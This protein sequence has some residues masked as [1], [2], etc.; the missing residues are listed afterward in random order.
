ME[1]AESMLEEK[2]Q[3]GEAIVLAEKLK[4]MRWTYKNW[5]R[6]RLSAVKLSVSVRDAIAEVQPEESA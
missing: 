3:P 2:R 6:E 5:M 4:T 1:V